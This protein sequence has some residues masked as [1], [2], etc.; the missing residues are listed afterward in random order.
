MPSDLGEILGRYDQVLVPEMNM[1]Q[2]AMLLRAKFLR[3]VTQLNKVQGQ[4]FKESEI[5]D[6]IH[7]LVPGGRQ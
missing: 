5:L 2:L 3:N 7:A 1:G 6:A 4:P